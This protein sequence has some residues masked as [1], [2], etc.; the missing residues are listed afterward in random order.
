MVCIRQVT[1]SSSLLDFPQDLLEEIPFTVLLSLWQP[2]TDSVKRELS[3]RVVTFVCETLSRGQ[4][5]SKPHPHRVLISLFASGADAL[6]CFA[7]VYGDH[8]ESRNYW[9]HLP[10]SREFLGYS[11]AIVPDVRFLRA[12]SSSS[13]SSPKT[14]H[15][16]EA[17]CGQ[18]RLPPPPKPPTRSFCVFFSSPFQKELRPN[19]NPPWSCAK[20]RFPFPLLPRCATISKPAHYRLRF[21]SQA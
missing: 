8:L 16:Y 17:P 9:R 7:L 18:S 6:V 12:L 4:F 1:I 21:L 20:Y 13:P 3:P 10:L 19:T 11:W 5:R 2:P 14:R 15:N